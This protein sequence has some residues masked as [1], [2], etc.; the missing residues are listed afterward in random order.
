MNFIDLTGIVL[1]GRGQQVLLLA[2]NLFEL[3][4]ELRRT[5]FRIY[6][7]FNFVLGFKKTPWH[8]RTNNPYNFPHK[9]F[10]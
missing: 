3:T 6:F 8:L 5:H 4:G 10:L 7:P 2:L 9:V 1:L